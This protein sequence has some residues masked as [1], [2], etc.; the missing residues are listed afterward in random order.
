MRAV[1]LQP[2]IE[3]YAGEFVVEGGQVTNRPKERGTAWERRV[4]DHAQAAGL[5][6][7]RAP[8]RGSADLLD[9]TG[10]QSAGF[11]VGCKA[12]S[13]SGSL[14][15][16]LGPAMVQGRR[17]AENWY[18]MSDQ[19]VLPVQVIQRSGY[20]VGE[21]YAVMEYDAFLRLVQRLVKAEGG[22]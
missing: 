3:T 8:L 7:D 15:D 14:A 12:I 13:R 19:E 18:R 20:S 17:A 16:K 22:R 4:A 21:A 1:P 2:M 5:P 9:L 6:W 11:L 10:C